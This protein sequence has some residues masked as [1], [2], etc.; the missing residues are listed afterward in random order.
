MATKQRARP[1]HLPE[2]YRVSWDNGASASGT[3]PYFFSTKREAVAFARQ[4]VRD[5]IAGDPNPREARHAYTWE[6]DAEWPDTTPIQENW[7]AYQ[8]RID[9]A[10]HG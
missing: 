3:F 8:A 2:G 5:M 6:I 1:S 4:W 7:N 9:R 10:S